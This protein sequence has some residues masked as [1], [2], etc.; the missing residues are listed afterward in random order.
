MEKVGYEINEARIHKGLPCGV[1]INKMLEKYL[2]TFN[3]ECEG[4]L[5]KC[6]Y[7][8]YEIKILNKNIDLN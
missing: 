6:L 4:K 2:N 7:Y 3:L 1:S 5:K 8:R